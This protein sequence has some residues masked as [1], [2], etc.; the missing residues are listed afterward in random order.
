MIWKVTKN[1]IKIKNRKERL[2]VILNKKRKRKLFA[3][4][5]FFFV[6][7]IS[8]FTSNF[9]LLSKIFR[10]KFKTETNEKDEETREREKEKEKIQ[11]EKYVIQFGYNWTCEFHVNLNIMKWISM[12]M[13]I[14]F[15]LFS[16]KDNIK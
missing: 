16:L 6:S 13:T 9:I 14:A 8:F 15:L 4:K 7:F 2:E 11:N 1:K 10:A 5:H 12:K 3:W